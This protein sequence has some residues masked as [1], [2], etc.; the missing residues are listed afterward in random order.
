MLLGSLPAARAGGSA[1]TTTGTAADAETDAFGNYLV[2]RLQDTAAVLSKDTFSL[3]PGEDC[4]A[5]S[6][7]SAQALSG[8]D[9]CTVT[10]PGSN[11]D[12]GIPFSIGTPQAGAEASLSEFDFTSTDTQIEGDLTFYAMASAAS[13]AT[14]GPDDSDTSNSPFF[15]TATSDQAMVPLLA[16]GLLI[17]VCRRMRVLES[18]DS[19]SK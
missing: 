11:D 8:N 18:S 16:G 14:T 19:T 15:L 6:P 10:H 3:A 13:E 17:A 4:R 9:A 2:L 1:I 5:G 12:Y 7:L